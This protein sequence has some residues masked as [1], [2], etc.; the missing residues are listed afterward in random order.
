MTCRGAT[1]CTGLGRLVPGGVASIAAGM[2]GVLLASMAFWAVDYRA[3]NR[4]H[5]PEAD[6]AYASLVGAAAPPLHI[7]DGEDV[8]MG[9]TRYVV[10]FLSEECGACGDSWAVAR[11]WHSGIACAVVAESCPESHGGEGATGRGTCMCIEDASGTV[12]AQFGVRGFPTAVVVDE[13][14]VIETA[15][16]GDVRVGKLLNEVGR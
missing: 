5:A 8:G 3:S 6:P 12:A 2:V 4:Q 10:L 16:L 11:S 1:D 7:R 15:A 9:G 14:G 13:D